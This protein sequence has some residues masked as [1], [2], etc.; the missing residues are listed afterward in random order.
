M[1]KKNLKNSKLFLM[2]TLDETT[3]YIIFV[4]IDKLNSFLS[5]FLKTFGPLGFYLISSIGHVS[6][7]ATLFFIF[8]FWKVVILAVLSSIWFVLDKALF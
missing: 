3:D 6:E 1:T 7:S 2:W 8:T 5:T 4:A